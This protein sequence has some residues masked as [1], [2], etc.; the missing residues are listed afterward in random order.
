ML[1]AALRARRCAWTLGVALLVA[2]PATAQRA[3]ATSGA[4]ALSIALGKSIVAL[5]GPWRFHTGDDP[6][7]ADPTFDD[8]SWETVDLT[9]QT[10]A[11]DPDVGLT[12]YVGGWGERGHR[13]YSGYA[14][15][16][17]RVSVTAPN[18]TRVA[19]GGPLEV[20]QAYQLFVNGRL[21]GGSGRFAGATPVVY[22]T[23]PAVF[24]LA[25]TTA[26]AGAA[27]NGELLI[28]VRVWASDAYMRE[29][30]TG[31]GIRIAPTIGSLG[32]V[33]AHHRLE[34]LAKFLGYV[35]EV[36][37]AAAFVLL[38]VMAT[39]VAR[40]QPANRAYR[41]LAVA[42]L[43]TAIARANQAIFF[44]TTWESARTAILIR[45]VFADPL[46]LGAWAMAWHSWF[47]LERRAW[48]L[49]TIG[50]LT[51]LSVL[52]ALVAVLDLGSASQ[53]AVS[54]ITLLRLAFVLVTAIII[55]LGVT[56]PAPKQ[57]LAIT[58]MILVSIGL[59]AQEVSALG[60]PGI[61][62][63]YGVGVS[64]T[65]FA[66]AAFALVAF[67]ML[68]LRL[69][70]LARERLAPGIRIGRHEAFD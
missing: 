25:D 38:A 14:W 60:I 3:A 65:Q 36:V 58:A 19:L 55:F 9:P 57:W 29:V 23:R 39:S 61:W 20:D 69:A 11:H 32:S 18:D 52:T 4:P 66:Y 56:R 62:F 10:G 54:V 33:T 24:T 8:A 6:R 59:Y 70:G 50:S 30:P 2:R 35:V 31:G 22:N 49:R 48:L 41:W 34:W 26:T 40:F 63:P 28:A 51:A 17:I 1:K 42:L 27:P 45:F 43:L 21:R 64:R 7:W 44:W 68:L 46:G 47:N 37:E 5:N 67:A 15:Y 13:G 53:A 16:R 12:G